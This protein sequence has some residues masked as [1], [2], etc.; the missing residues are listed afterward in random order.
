MSS[1]CYKGSLLR[2]SHIN[3]EAVYEAFQVLHNYEWDLSRP[4][5]HEIS[6]CHNL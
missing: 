1:K 3:V 5:N 4:E 6:T 2:L